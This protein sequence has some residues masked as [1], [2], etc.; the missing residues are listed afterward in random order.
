[1][2]GKL[3]LFIYWKLVYNLVCIYFSSRERE[4]GI[5]CWQIMNL[6][7]KLRFLFQNYSLEVS[8]RCDWSRVAGCLAVIGARGHESL[9]WLAGGSH[10]RFRI[11]GELYAGSYQPSRSSEINGLSSKKRKKRCKNCTVHRS[12]VT[13]NSDNDAASLIALK[14]PR[15]RRAYCYLTPLTSCWH[16]LRDKI[17]LAASFQPEFWIAEVITG[18]VPMASPHDGPGTHRHLPRSQAQAHAA[19]VVICHFERA[20]L[21]CRSGRIL[22]MRCLASALRCLLRILWMKFLTSALR[23][24]LWI[25]V[26]RFSTVASLIF[27]GFLWMKFV[28]V[29]ADLGYIKN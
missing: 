24:L 15:R 13:T 3:R 16:Y 22:W 1:M 23:Y 14:T 12:H 27:E 18:V 5:C 11:G 9:R 2:E 6:W 20:C 29:L 25:L 8:A 17:N 21:F 19:G 7:C 4:K 10:G 28:F 26:I